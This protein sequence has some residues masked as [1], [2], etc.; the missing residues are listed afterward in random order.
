[1]R[2]KLALLLAFVLA[3]AITIP[4]LATNRINAEAYNDVYC[5]D[6]CE[7]IIEG[8]YHDEIQLALMQ[9]I[10]KANFA[11][12]LGYIDNVSDLQHLELQ[13]FG[14]IEPHNGC[15]FFGS[16]PCSFTS[17]S[18][19][20]V[21]TSHNCPHRACLFARGYVS[22]CNWG[23]GSWDTRLGDAWFDWCMNSPAR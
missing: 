21:V 20:A 2:K 18:F 17:W 15:R 13:N 16:V 10:L 7:Y 1:M 3:L 4:V 23:C 22:Y 12:Y 8:D 9:L 14:M 5:G 6:C 19:L 11:L